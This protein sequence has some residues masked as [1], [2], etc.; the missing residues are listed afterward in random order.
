M[1]R[2]RVKSFLRRMKTDNSDFLWE[3]QIILIQ[4]QFLMM[5]LWIQCHI[6]FQRNHFK[7]GQVPQAI[8]PATVSQS[9]RKTLRI[10]PTM[11]WI[12]RNHIKEPSRIRV[13][14][15]KSQHKYILII[16]FIES[17]YKSIIFFGFG[18]QILLNA[19]LKTCHPCFLSEVN[20]LSR[21]KPFPPIFKPSF[22]F[23]AF[24]F[25]FDLDKIF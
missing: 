25:S 12:Y 22:F 11:H 21:C 10:L 2:A 13:R 1:L 20:S 16:T 23:I 19:L 4:I 9:G 18:I 3:L 8:L 6:P 14:E 24:I 17:N 7:L 15:R 5:S